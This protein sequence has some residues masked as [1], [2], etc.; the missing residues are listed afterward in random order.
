[1]SRILVTGG[2]GFIGS[3]YVLERVLEGDVVL[4]LDNLT[5]ASNIENLSAV[6]GLPN[7]YFQKG[8]ICD[9]ELV[10]ELLTSFNPD[11]VVNFAAETHVDRS[12]VNPQPFIQTNINGTFNLLHQSNGWWQSNSRK[13]SGF[14]FIQISTDEVFGSLKFGEPAFTE[15][16]C[17][18]PSSPYSSSKASSDLIALAYFKTFGFPVIVTNCS[19]NYGPR[20]FPEKLIPFM[21]DSALKGKDLPIYGDGSNI[22]DWLFV[23]DHCSAVEAI[24]KYGKTGERY[25]IGGNCELSNLEIVKIIC[26]HLDG[27]KPKTSGHYQEQIKFVTDRPG[28]D[29]RYAINSNK[30]KKELGWRPE[31]SFERGISETLNWYLNNQAWMDNIK[32]RNEFSNWIKNN[33]EKR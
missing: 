15:S 17:L 14:K 13:K 32:K 4:N 6:E 23:K 21:L 28:H 29:L 16:T 22:R 33:Y 26:S 30:L 12:I 1:M 7:Y 24:R 25:L 20:Q 31:Y 18:A 9:P 10:A 8:D 11:S 3:C 5:Y 19:N 27:V 2:A